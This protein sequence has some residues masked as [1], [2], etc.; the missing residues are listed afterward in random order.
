MRKRKE[1]NSFWV[2]SILVMLTFWC[3]WNTIRINNAFIGV[4]DEVFTH[5]HILDNAVKN[6]GTQTSNVQKQLKDLETKFNEGLN[7]LPFGAAW[8]T[9]YE[10]YGE[11]YIFRWQDNLYTTNTKEGDVSWQQSKY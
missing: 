5:I 10:E 4:A 2:T 7:A 6:L 9:M 1:K 8:R 11:G 3:T